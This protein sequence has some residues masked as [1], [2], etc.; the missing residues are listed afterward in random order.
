MFRPEHQLQVK[1]QHLKA[2]VCCALMFEKKAH[3]FLN[4]FTSFYMYFNVSL[5]QQSST[6]CLY[7]VALE[8]EALFINAAYAPPTPPPPTMSFHLEMN[9]HVILEMHTQK[10]RGALA[11][12]PPTPWSPRRAVRCNMTG[13]L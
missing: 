7:S 6:L 1:A 3:L 13:V 5:K 2:P 8:A 10:G 11:T 9:M 4:I 12:A